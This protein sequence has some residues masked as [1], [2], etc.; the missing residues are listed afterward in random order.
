[1]KDEK[2]KVDL[3]KLAASQKTKEK[4]LNTNETVKK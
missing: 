3:D 1:M 2:T 4:Q